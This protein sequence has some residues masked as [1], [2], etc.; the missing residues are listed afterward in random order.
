MIKILIPAFNEQGNIADVVNDFSKH[1]DVVVCDNES[2]DS[3][4]EEARNAGAKVISSKKGKGNAVRELLKEESGIYVLVD[5]DG[6]FNAEYL[7]M[8]LG[9]LRAGSA[10][11]VIGKRANINIHNRNSMLFRRISL[12]LLQWIFN[13]RF[14]KEQK[15]TDFL[16]GMRAFKRDVR[17][18][19][20]LKSN[21]FGIEAEM[22]IQAIRSNF[23]IKEVEV[24]VRPRKHGRQSSNILNVGIPV[25]R[26][27]LFS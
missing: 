17:D 26:E 16:S 14:G 19:L 27:I 24:P 13:L 23:K 22:T 11:I 4:A 9:P 18:R 25:L 2:T 21:G 8:I 15:I 1:G 12:N 6:A 20:K 3:T 10:D 7:P 5:G